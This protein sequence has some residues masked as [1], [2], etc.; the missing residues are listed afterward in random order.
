MKRLNKNSSRIGNALNNRAMTLTV[1][2][3]IA[4]LTVFPARSDDQTG[5]QSELNRADQIAI[6]RELFNRDWSEHKATRGNGL[7][8]MYN[9]TSCAACHPRGGAR[10]NQRI[11]G[12]GGFTDSGGLTTTNTN[13][14]LLSVVDRPPTLKSARRRFDK[15]VRQAHPLFSVSSPHIVLHKFGEDFKGLTQRHDDY[16]TT[17][18]DEFGFYT[19]IPRKR[20][21]RMRGINVQISVRSTPALFGA[22]LI[23]QVKMSD[24]VKIARQQAGSNSEISGRVAQTS[25]GRVGR[26]GWRGQVGSL[27]EFV[28]QACANE[29]GLQV[30]GHD[31][32]ENA[33]EKARVRREEDGESRNL[34]PRNS[35]L[36]LTVPETQALAL[37]VGSLPAPE[38]VD[39]NSLG[40]TEYA[41]AG[42]KLFHKIGCSACHVEHVG[43]ALGIYSDLLLHDMG[44]DLADPVA[45]FPAVKQVVTQSSNF[46]GGAFIEEVADVK[47]KLDQE[48]RTPPLWGV[49]DSPPYLHDG[50]ARTLDAAIRLHG[51]EAS[52]T[53]RR[54]IALS[55]T[56]RHQLVGFLETLGS[57]GSKPR[58]IKPT[59]QGIPLNR[60]SGGNVF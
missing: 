32:V 57:P 28:L 36:D 42:E 60:F 31:E 54:Y 12:L 25:D 52:S 33:V 59:P 40:D 1:A 13:V 27:N 6:G 9:A 44:S 49:A 10:E 48:W 26:F 2:F 15:R 30:K 11:G 8:P 56:Q 7:G 3:L 41:L 34:L 29:L 16:L 47:T 18:R 35:Q 4:G 50:R 20:I 14:F 46:Y 37:F 38:Q 17:I 23:D 58:S 19:D 43:P 55:K 39:G 21:V 24:L 5:T 45:A 53:R 22:G 51:G